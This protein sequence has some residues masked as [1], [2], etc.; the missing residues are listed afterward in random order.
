[1]LDPASRIPHDPEALL[2][3]EGGR[4]DSLGLIN[5]MVAVEERLEREHG[6]VVTLADEEAFSATE[7]P[8]RTVATL[9]AH[10][11]RRLADG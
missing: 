9:R 4:L 7:S 6:V 8:F 2:V 3:G 11:A 5:L 10:V 1:M